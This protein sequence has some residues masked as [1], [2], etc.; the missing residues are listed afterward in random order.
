MT[1]D[2]FSETPITTASD[3]VFVDMRREIVEGSIVQGSKISEP[4]LAK[5]YGVSR[6]TLREALNRLES[7]SSSQCA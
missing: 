4:E 7:I 3:Q 2:A 1:Q 5:R 6:A